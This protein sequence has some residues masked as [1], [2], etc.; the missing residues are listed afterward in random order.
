MTIRANKRV[1]W[2]ERS[3]PIVFHGGNRGKAMGFAE[4][5]IGPATSG[6][7]RWLYPSCKLLLRYVVAADQCV[8][9]VRRV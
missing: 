7:T 5:V 2:V 4:L 1:V 3:E 9:G 8:Q 6:R